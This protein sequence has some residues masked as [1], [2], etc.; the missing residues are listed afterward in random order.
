MSDWNRAIIEEFRANG[1]VVGGPFEGR[2]LLLLHT[3]GRRSGIE[4]VTPLTY[5]PRDGRVFVFASNAGA[6]HHPAW[7]HNLVARPAT[8]YEIGTETRATKARE[9]SGDDRDTVYAAQVAVWDIFGRYEA[10]THRR[11]PVVELA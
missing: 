7:Y 3:I 4:R 5:L 2:P 8:T 1:G 9:L 6:D 10:G 11:I